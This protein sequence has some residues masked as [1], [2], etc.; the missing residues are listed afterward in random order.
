[1]AQLS[2]EGSLVVT[3]VQ[4]SPLVMIL[5]AI[6]MLI[7]GR[8]GLTTFELPRIR[9]YPTVPRPDTHM[10]AICHRVIKI[11]LNEILSIA[12]KRRLDQS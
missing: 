1:M 3:N 12:R 11:T 4:R 8:M 6:L 10:I 2:A 7:R 5:I 9:D